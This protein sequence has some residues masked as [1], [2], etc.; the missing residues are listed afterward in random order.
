[1]GHGERGLGIGEREVGS[2]GWVVWT[3]ELGRGCGG[4]TGGG[5]GLGSE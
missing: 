2:K 3:G 5:G 4:R 1:M